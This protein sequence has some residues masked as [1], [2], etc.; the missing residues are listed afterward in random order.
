LWCC[1]LLLLLLLLWR[2]GWGS[3]RLKRILEVSGFQEA[4]QALRKL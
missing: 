3:R 4:Q 2:K 1:N